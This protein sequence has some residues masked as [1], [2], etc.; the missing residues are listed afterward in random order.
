[1]NEERNQVTDIIVHLRKYKNITSKVAIEKYGATRLSGI[2]F[3]LR[4]RGFVI[5]TEIKQMKN[6]YGHTTNYAMYHLKKDVKE[7]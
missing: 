7:G 2:I 3:K 4:Q 1:M 6:R 5:E